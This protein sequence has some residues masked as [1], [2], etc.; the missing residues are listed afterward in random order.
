MTRIDFYT[1]EKSRLQIGCKLVVKAIS[2]QL[3]VMIYAPE[4]SMAQAIDKLLWTDQATAFVP[5]CF[6]TDRLALETP[7]LIA[8]NLDNS[9][10]DDL[11]L[12]LSD[13]CPTAFGRYR[14][15][16]EIVSL[17]DGNQDT[18][19]IRWRHYKERGYEVNHVNLNKG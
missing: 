14:R 11:L 19:R 4:D 3:K 8:T 9:G 6:A 10:P 16:I 7:V 13:S 15:L 1:T 2:Q 12:N 18:A 5:H 17:S